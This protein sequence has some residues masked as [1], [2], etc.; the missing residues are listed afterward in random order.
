MVDETHQCNF[1]ERDTIHALGRLSRFGARLRSWRSADFEIVVKPDVV[2][3]VVGRGFTGELRI[4][5]DITAHS[6]S[7]AV[8]V[9]DG[10]GGSIDEFRC[11]DGLDA[12]V[13]TVAVVVLFSCGHS[14]SDIPP[15][16]HRACIGTPD[17]QIG[18]D[19]ARGR[20]LGEGRRCK[21][22]SERI[23]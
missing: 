7:C 23:E 5:L 9:E 3:V 12:I 4:D 6:G 21:Q 22:W 15:A 16:S 19:S 13:R 2:C 14:P 17:N 20:R 11:H 18:Q 8:Y 1:A 10:L